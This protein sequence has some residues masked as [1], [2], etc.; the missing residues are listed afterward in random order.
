MEELFVVTALAVILF[1]IPVI[2]LAILFTLIKTAGLSV[3]PRAIIGF[4]FRHFHMGVVDIDIQFFP[5]NIM[6]F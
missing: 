1:V 5:F 4:S 6:V 2:A 3:H